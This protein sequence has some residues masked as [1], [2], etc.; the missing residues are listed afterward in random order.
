MLA[1]CA[2]VTM[3]SDPFPVTKTASEIEV[4]RT[5]KPDRAY[6]EIGEIKCSSSSESICLNKIK[7]KASELGAEAIIITGSASTETKTQT[8][9]Y[10]LTASTSKDIGLKAIAIKYK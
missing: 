3:Y 2:T 6:I 5:T 1:G 9:Q 7:K 4:Y 10:G 8:L